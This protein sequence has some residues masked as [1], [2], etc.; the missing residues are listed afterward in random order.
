MLCSG[1]ISDYRGEQ[2]RV[3]EQLS[4]AQFAEFRLQVADSS[5]RVT[6]GVQCQNKALSLGGVTLIPSAGS[7]AGVV[8]T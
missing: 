1:D 7:K 3:P 8:W 2:T 4:N 6:R 5:M